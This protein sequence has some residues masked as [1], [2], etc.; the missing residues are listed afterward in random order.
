M[1]IAF[2]GID[3]AGKSS[4]INKLLVKSEFSESLVFK[5]EWRDNSDRLFRLHSP[6]PEGGDFL[7]EGGYAIQQKWAYSLDYLV[8]VQRE[9]IPQI[10]AAPLG[11]HFFFDRWTPC[12]LAWANMV[13]NMDESGISALLQAFPVVDQVVF[14]ETDA[15]TAYSRIQRRGGAKPDEAINVLERFME[16]YESVLPTVG[17]PIY[18]VQN[19]DLDDTASEV[20]HHLSSLV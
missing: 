5:K 6:R 10:D 7:L 11:S 13:T 14:V 4:L 15:A 17:V 16:A 9:V 20:F 19:E 2:C 1:R 8:Y 12:I 3:G 18:R